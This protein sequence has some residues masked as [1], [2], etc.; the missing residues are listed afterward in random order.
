[1]KIKRI[2]PWKGIPEA[3]LPPP[4][5]TIAERPRDVYLAGCVAVADRLAERGFHYAP[6]RQHLTRD[7]SPFRE[8]IK[9][10]SSHFNQSGVSVAL[11]PHVYVE[12]R[13]FRQWR[14]DH[15][16][17]PSAFVAGGLL[18]VIE[19]TGFRDYNL[20]DRR[21]RQAVLDALC[22]DLL[23]IGMR[24]FDLVESENELLAL[25]RTSDVPGFTV[26][27]L[28]E[29]L[30][31]LGRKKECESILAGWVARFGLKGPP[32]GHRDRLRPTAERFNLAVDLRE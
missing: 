20:A 29:W 10:Q 2:G 12:N 6:S 31:F 21:S 1:V 22:S 17:Q 23:R 28:V 8:V 3:P 5:L 27:G 18:G 30:L 25:A 15:G 19:G 7:R 9:F 4:R 13:E 14:A 11:L 16:L 26:D 32:V 24:W